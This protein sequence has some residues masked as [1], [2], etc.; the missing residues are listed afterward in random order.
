MVDIEKL[1]SSINALEQ[2]S[3]NFKNISTIISE[4]K[5]LIE[6][7]KDNIDGLKSLSNTVD[8][9]VLKN[10]EI[11]D[12]FKD[13]IIKKKEQDSLFESRIN[14]IL[15]ELKNESNK[16]YSSFEKAVTINLQS[17]GNNLQSVIN[18]TSSEEISKL[19]ILNKDIKNIS[20]VIEET[21]QTINTELEKLNEVNCNIKNEFKNTKILVILG[22][23]IG[24]INSILMFYIIFR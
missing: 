2:S 23:L 1:E 20:S 12:N 16:L 24:F 3:E 14:T 7:Y 6:E 10:T 11:L 17:I 5:V 8:G 19:D 9:V 21:S 22:L 4:A 15:L 13:Y 18:K